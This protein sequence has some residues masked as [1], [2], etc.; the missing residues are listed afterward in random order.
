[1][2][3]PSGEKI[4]PTIQG[5]SMSRTVTEKNKRKPVQ[6][7]ERRVLSSHTALIQDMRD[8]QGEISQSPELALAFLKRAGLVSAAGKPKQLIRD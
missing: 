4:G 7:A 5:V 8:F 3:Y 6:A 1:M 2:H